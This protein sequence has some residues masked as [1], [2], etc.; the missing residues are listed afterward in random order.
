[1]R[2]LVAIIEPSK[3]T[4]CGI[5]ADMCPPKIIKIKDGTASIDELVKCDGLGGCARLCPSK[6]ITME[7]RDFPS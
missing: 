7:E 2:K 4:G 3:C 5:C 1:M 6:A